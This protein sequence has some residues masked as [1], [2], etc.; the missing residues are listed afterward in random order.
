M[1]WTRRIR[2]TWPLNVRFLDHRGDV[3]EAIEERQLLQAVYLADDSVAVRLGDPYHPIIFG[4]TSVSAALLRPDADN[5]RILWALDTIFGELQPASLHAPQV[6]FQWLLP[7]DQS[8]DEARSA[9]AR[10][11]FGD[12]TTSIEDWSV[13]I[14]GRLTSPDLWYNAE[15]GII[16]A[17]EAPERLSREVGSLTESSPDAPSSLWTTESVPSVA[18]FFDVTAHLRE[19]PGVSAAEVFTLMESTQDA[20]TTLMLERMGKFIPEVTN[21]E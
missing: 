13:R 17:A 2:L 6:S 15:F 16:E 4:I 7:L 12:G 8:Y 3:L 5:E 20:L 18:A 19:G 21:I 9:A 1:P 11:G 10:T 14:D